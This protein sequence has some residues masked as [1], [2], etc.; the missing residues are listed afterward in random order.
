MVVTL[1]SKFVA[2]GAYVLGAI[3]GGAVLRAL[4]E[5]FRWFER[6]DTASSVITSEAIRLAAPVVGALTLARWIRGRTAAHSSR[7]RGIIIAWSAGA[8]IGTVALR[9]LQVAVR[10][11]GHADTVSSAITAEALRFMFPV[12]GALVVRRCCRDYAKRTSWP[13]RPFGRV[14]VAAA[15]VIF[16]LYLATWAFGVP[17]AITHLVNSDVADYKRVYAGKERLYWERYPF[18]KASFGAP[19]L[20]GIVLVYYESQLGGQWGAGGWHVFAWWA[21]AQRELYF[22]WRWLS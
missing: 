6:A 1:P 22:S 21:V 13:D 11:I 14:R 8:V 12:V 15:A 10:W 18:Q 16:G 9:S 17:A 3:A 7:W 20:P 4:E 2:M 5:L 19:L